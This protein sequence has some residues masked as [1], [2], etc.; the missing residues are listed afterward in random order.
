MGRKLC[1]QKASF[2]YPSKGVILWEWVNPLPNDKI[3]DQSKSKAFAD[4]KINKTQKP[5][6]VMG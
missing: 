2:P 3:L 6:F 1:F 5:N 4:N